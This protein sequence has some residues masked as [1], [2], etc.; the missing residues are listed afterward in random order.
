MEL[1]EWMLN[2]I[3]IVFLLSIPVGI[4][5]S[6][7]ELIIKIKCFNLLAQYK[8]FGGNCWGMRG[9]GNNNCHLKR[10]CPAYQSAI[11][12]EVVA[13]LESMLQK[14]RKELKMESKK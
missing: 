5:L 6:I 8:F 13:E 9:C 2:A 7:I 14:R 12:P 1:I 10:F 4:V 3:F 11:T